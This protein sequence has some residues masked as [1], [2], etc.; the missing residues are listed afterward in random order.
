MVFGSHQFIGDRVT[1]LI[2]TWNYTNLHNT[3]VSPST[4]VYYFLESY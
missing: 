1:R 2:L 3:M 4:A